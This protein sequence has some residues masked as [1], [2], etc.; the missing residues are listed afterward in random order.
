MTRPENS[1]YRTGEGYLDLTPTMLN[2]RIRIES[3]R[4]ESTSVT[5]DVA[6]VENVNNLHSMFNQINIYFNQKLVLPPNNA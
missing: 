4:E 3:E 1:L 6:K 5:P 2:L